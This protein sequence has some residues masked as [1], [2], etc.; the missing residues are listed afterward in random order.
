VLF[1]A[2]LRRSL[3]LEADLPVTP[4]RGYM[5]SLIMYC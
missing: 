1:R 5:D 3:A 4:G 2:R